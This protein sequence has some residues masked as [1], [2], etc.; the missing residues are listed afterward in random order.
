V[1]YD[2]TIKEEEST[3]LAAG[4]ELK[5]YEPGVGVVKVQTKGVTAIL[6]HVGSVGG[7]TQQAPIS[8]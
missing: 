5:W 8:R 6:F 3:R 2:G 4:T 1:K 7:L